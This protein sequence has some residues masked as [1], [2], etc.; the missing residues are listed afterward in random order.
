[1]DFPIRRF[2]RIEDALVIFPAGRQ[3]AG[4]FFGWII[5]GRIGLL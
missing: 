4:L 5:N 2:E 1:M 3:S